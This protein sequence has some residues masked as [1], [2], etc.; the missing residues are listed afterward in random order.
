MNAYDEAMKLFDNM[1]GYC[2]TPQEIDMMCS[3]EKGDLAHLTC[4]LIKERAKYQKLNKDLGNMVIQMTGSIID[5]EKHWYEF[6]KFL[7]EN[8]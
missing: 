6:Q 7:N 2:T 8:Q 5:L 4:F 1:E 3:I